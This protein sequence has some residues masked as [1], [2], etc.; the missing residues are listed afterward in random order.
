M[1]SQD[2]LKETQHVPLLHVLDAWFVPGGRFA[3]KQMSFLECLAK[4]AYRRYLCT[5]AYE[6]AKG[7]LPRSS[8]IYGEENSAPN[9]DGTWQ[10][11]RVLTNQIL[12]LRDT[13]W[14]YEMC[15]AISDGDIGRVVEVIKV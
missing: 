13:L 15:K 3:T 7:H 11:D 4:V 6:D 9:D 12:Q 1:C 5:A 8:E 10:G 14:Y 2:T